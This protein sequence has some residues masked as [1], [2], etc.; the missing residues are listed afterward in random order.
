MR[1]RKIR[2]RLEIEK[3]FWSEPSNAGNRE[4]AVKF[5]YPEVTSPVC[6]TAWVHAQKKQMA[7]LKWGQAL[8]GNL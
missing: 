2:K 7:G 8:P 1:E 6:F 5:I 4:V 3:D